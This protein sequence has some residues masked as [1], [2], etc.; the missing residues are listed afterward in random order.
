V[1]SRSY[2]SNLRDY[3]PSS[4]QIQQ[5]G[6]RVATSMGAAKAAAA[7]SMEAN[8]RP[9]APRVVLWKAFE[10]FEFGAG[11]ERFVFLVL[12]LLDGFQ[13]YRKLTF[14]IACPWANCTA[15]IAFASLCQPLFSAALAVF[16][17]VY[18]HC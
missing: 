12:G 13:V 16:I 17:R 7:S 3:L 11:G 10:E 5:L 6:S 4:E 18:A 8:T 2:L 1:C 14:F 15:Q 9:A